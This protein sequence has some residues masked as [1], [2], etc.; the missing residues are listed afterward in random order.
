MRRA[1]AKPSTQWVEIISE[2]VFLLSMCICILAFFI[3][4]FVF[5]H[6]KKVKN[7][8]LKDIIRFY[9]VEYSAFLLDFYTQYCFT[10]KA[11]IRSRMYSNFVKFSGKREEIVIIFTNG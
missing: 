4:K 1:A 10:R 9:F 5:I 11:F 6:V 2:L 3:M 8:N 7:E